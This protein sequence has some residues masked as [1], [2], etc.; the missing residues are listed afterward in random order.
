MDKGYRGLVRLLA[1]I[2]LANDSEAKCITMLML[3]YIV[4]ETS[5]LVLEDE[6]NIARGNVSFVFKNKIGSFYL[7]TG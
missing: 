1:N 6:R 7:E 5:D 4:I 3:K 2:A